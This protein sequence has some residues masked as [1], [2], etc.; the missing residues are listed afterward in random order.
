MRMDSSP[1][2]AATARKREWLLAGARG[3]LLG[4]LCAALA[5]SA[6]DKTVTNKELGFEITFPETWTAQEKPAAPVVLQF[7]SPRARLALA[8]AAISITVNDLQL[9]TAKEYVED[10]FSKNE[11]LKRG[12]V[13]SDEIK[14]GDQDAM[15]CTFIRTPG[16]LL[17]KEV[18]YVIVA[19]DHGYFISI[20]AAKNDF[21]H[22]AK[23]IDAI[24]KSFKL[25]PVEKK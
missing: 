1:F 10:L 23:D 24:V 18:M 19:N 15:K 12:L 11:K 3:S 22:Y 9:V 2:R 17:T 14:V 13:D 4:L 5:I 20:G 7:V 16:G 8:S 6:A 21:D 25:L